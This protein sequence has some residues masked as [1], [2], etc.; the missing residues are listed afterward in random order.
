MNNSLVKPALLAAMLHLHTVLTSQADA[1]ILVTNVPLD[2]ELPLEVPVA[3]ENVTTISFPA[4]IQ[5]IDAAGITTDGREPGLF[6]LAYIP[7]NSFFSV[8]ALIPGGVAN[9]NVRSAQK[10]YVLV[11]K[12]SKMPWLAVNLGQ[13]PPVTPVS[14]AAPALSTTQLLGLL[15]VA[16]NYPALKKHHPQLVADVTVAQPRSV[17]DYPDF[18]VKLEEV[19]RFDAADALAFHLT[20]KSKVQREVR[21]RSGSWQVRVGDHLFPQFIAD[22]N[23]I[24]PALGEETVWFLIQGTPDGQRSSLSV[25]NTF[26]ILVNPN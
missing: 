11:L 8:R 12:E 4:A 20:L 1:Q 17:T 7:L 21:Y 25:H 10:T 19:F 2:A 16:R 24:L 6:Q 3:I 26:V 14:P 5:A 9:V 18:V 13:R 15:D 23:G 22:G